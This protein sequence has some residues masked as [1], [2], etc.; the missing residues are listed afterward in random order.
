MASAPAS[1]RHA[2]SQQ[3]QCAQP[4]YRDAIAKPQLGFADAVNGDIRRLDAK[5]PSG[6]QSRPA[7]T[8]SGRCAIL[9]WRMSISPKTRSPKANSLTLPPSAATTPQAARAAV[10]GAGHRRRS[11]IPPRQGPRPPDAVPHQSAC[12]Q[13]CGYRTWRRSVPCFPDA[14]SVCI[15]T[16]SAPRGTVFI[17]QKRWLHR[18]RLPRAALAWLAILS[19]C[20][21]RAAAPACHHAAIVKG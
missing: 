20:L 2:R 17:I 19:S 11:R 7:A 3:A 8:A 4:D 14:I 13:M 10:P 12:P 1:P 6:D 21:V 5:R 16:S 15:K 18:A 9:V